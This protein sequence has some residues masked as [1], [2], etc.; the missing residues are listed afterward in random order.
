VTESCERGKDE[1]FSFPY[2]EG[3]FC[4]EELLASLPI[5]SSMELVS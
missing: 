4:T 3:N 5:I 1:D 2:N